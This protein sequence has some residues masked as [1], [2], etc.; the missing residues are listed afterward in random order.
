MPHVLNLRERG[1][2]VAA[3]ASQAW[4]FMNARWT[5]SMAKRAAMGNRRWLKHIF[6]EV[7][8]IPPSSVFVFYW[9]LLVMTLVVYSAMLIPTRLGFL[10]KGSGFTLVADYVMEVRWRASAA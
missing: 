5:L 4:E 3:L 6:F 2:M 7:S 9:N 8:C 1:A 10:T